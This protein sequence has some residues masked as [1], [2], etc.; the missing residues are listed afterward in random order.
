MG[1]QGA[2]GIMGSGRL[3]SRYGVLLV[4]VICSATVS[5]VAASDAAD[6][7]EVRPE[8]DASLPVAPATEGSAVAEPA[9]AGEQAEKPETGSAE[10]S[11]SR[12]RGEPL[13]RTPSREK[14]SRERLA[15][16]WEKTKSFLKAVPAFVSVLWHSATKRERGEKF[17]DAYYKNV[18]SRF[19]KD[20]D[21]EKHKRLLQMM[22][23][24]SGKPREKVVVGA[25]VNYEIYNCKGPAWAEYAAKECTDLMRQYGRI[26]DKCE[27]CS[28]AVK[29][30][31]PFTPDFCAEC[32]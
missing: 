14:S 12:L 18:D 17:S 24:F 7:K 11:A 5:I 1:H 13:S 29:F 8:G 6:R 32:P 9:V 26:E 2:L 3:F 21:P 20:F 28:M 23:F 10:K 19:Q 30:K 15:E 4:F 25:D 27:F 31:E 16:G 22:V